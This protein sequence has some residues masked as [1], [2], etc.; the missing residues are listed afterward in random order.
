MKKRP[1]VR[2]FAFL[3]AAA[4]I[5]PSVVVFPVIPGS[6]VLL[7]TFNSAVF[8]KE[9]ITVKSAVGA[10]LVFLALVVINFL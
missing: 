6:F 10:A 2:A 3:T 8:F 4:A 9:R 7:S 1:I 5:L